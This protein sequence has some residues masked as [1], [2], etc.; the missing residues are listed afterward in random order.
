MVTLGTS[1]NGQS[2]RGVHCMD[3]QRKWLKNDRDQLIKVGIC[4]GEVSNKSELT[5]FTS[6]NEPT[7]EGGE[8]KESLRSKLKKASVFDVPII[9]FRFMGKTHTCTCYLTWWL[10]FIYG[11]LDPNVLS[12]WVT[13]SIGLWTLSLPKVAKV[14]VQQNSKFHLVKC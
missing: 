14:K 11:S 7:Q 10:K 4:Y 6:K 3:S 2:Y 9:E 8:H 13:N 12:S 1:C 5:R